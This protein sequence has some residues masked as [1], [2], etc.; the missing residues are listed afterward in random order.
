MMRRTLLCSALCT[1][2]A[3]GTVYAQS[4]AI[5]AFR[6][7]ME[8]GAIGIDVP[9]VV[10]IPVPEAYLE[11][12]QFA[13]ED[14]TSES[15]EPYLLLEETPAVSLSVSAQGASGGANAMIDGNTITYAEFLLP[16]DTQGQAQITIT[17]TQPVT[18]STLS[19]LLDNYVALPTFVEVRAQTDSGEKILVA[20]S[21]MNS[22]TVRFPKT[23]SKSWTVLLTYGQLLRI[24]EIRLDEDTRS[25]GPTRAVRFLAQPEHSYRIYLDPDRHVKIATGESG[26]LHADEDVLAL[27][28]MASKKN[29]S[30]TTADTDNDTVPD[31]EDNCVQLSN[32]DQKDINENGRGDACDDFDKDGLLNSS[33]NCPEKPNRNQND[34]DG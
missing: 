20:R 7:F 29:S 21:R 11:R 31:L 18:S 26:N 27:P 23:T 9:T 8:I 30:Y 34:T 5:N 33:D 14:T 2:A 32:K 17:S 25:G 12:T 15:F 4:G 19:V 28:A 1:F 13:V 3:A 24:T 22:Q 16:E 10:E 6:L